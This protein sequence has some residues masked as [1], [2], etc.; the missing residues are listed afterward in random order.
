MRTFE[1]WETNLPR[2]GMEGFRTLAKIVH[3]HYE[4]IFAYWDSPSRITNAYTE[5]LNGLIKIANRMGRGYSYEI[6]R[7][8]TLYARQ[9]RR[10]GSGVRLT[11]VAG[12]PK[13]VEYGPHIPTL[14][15]IAEL[16]GL[17]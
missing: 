9:A 6:I 15:E 5:C 10:V 17:E 2:R 7:A 4:D 14:V 11:D 16:G 8:K 3:N 13:T 12:T 1:E